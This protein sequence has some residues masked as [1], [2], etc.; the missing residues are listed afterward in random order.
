MRRAVL[1]EKMAAVEREPAPDG[2]L[3]LGGLQA[4]PDRVERAEVVA[5]VKVV[6]PALRGLLAVG[7]RPV[8]CCLATE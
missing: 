3:E 7:P 8:G 1:P 6:D 2:R 5:G 4:A